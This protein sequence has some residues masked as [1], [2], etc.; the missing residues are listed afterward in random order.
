MPGARPLVPWLCPT[1]SVPFDALTGF[2]TRFA[3]GIALVALGA[4]LR[5]ASYWALGSLFTFEVVIKDDH[6]LVTRGP[7]RYV[8]H[9][10]YTGAALVLLGT[11]LIHFGAAGYVTQCRIENTPVVVFVWI[12]RVGTV[13]S[14]LSLGR[15]CSVE[16]HQ[17]R[18]RFGQVWEEY[19]VDV[20]YR[21]LPYIY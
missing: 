21:L 10:S 8:R 13:F 15:R 11:H 19:R 20:P 7:Y 18:E 5:A 1:P 4:L 6:S 9:P 14:V 2:P 16:D 12:W 3:A 17:L